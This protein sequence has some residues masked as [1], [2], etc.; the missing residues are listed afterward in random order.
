M[1]GRESR[2]TER[3][4]TGERGQTEE[5]ERRD[6]QWHTARVSQRNKRERGLNKFTTTFILSS[7]FVSKIK[8]EDF[9]VRTHVCKC[10]R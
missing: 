4:G 2:Q 10:N 1:A 9:N 8:A 7:R 5:R 3:E 6:R